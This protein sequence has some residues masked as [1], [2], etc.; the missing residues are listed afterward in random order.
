M[1]ELCCLFVTH[2]SQTNLAAELPQGQ[3]SSSLQI[4]VTIDQRTWASV[5][6]HLIAARIL[7]S[8]SL[9]KFLVCSLI[10]ILNILLFLTLNLYLYFCA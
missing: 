1:P 7:P 4:K 2:M 10:D 8:T 6:S 3:I 5:Q 9:F